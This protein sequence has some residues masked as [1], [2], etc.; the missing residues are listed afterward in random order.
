MSREKNTA[1]LK[2]T[3]SLSISVVITKILG[4]AFKVPLS[5]VLGDEGMGYFNTA[6]AIYGFFYI[7][8]TAGVPKSLA[9]VLASHS[10]TSS[11]ETDDKYILKCALRLFAKIGFVSTLLNIICAP[12]MARLVGNKNACLSILAIAPSILFVSLSGVLRGYLNSSEKLTPI[13]ISQLI[14]GSIKLALGLLLAMIGVK[15]SASVSVISAL[16]IFGITVGS[17]ISFLYMLIVAFSTKSRL[18][19]KQND[20]YSKKYIRRQIIKN[21]LPIALCSSLLNL[22]STVDLTIIIKRLVAIGMSESYANSMYGNYTT[23]AVPMFMLIIAVLSP[24]A[25]SYMPRLTNIFVKGENDRF[26]SELNKLTGITLLISVPAS[27]AFYF[28]SFDLLDILFSVQSSA[29]GA[30]MLAYLSFGVP[31]LSLLTVINT[32]LESQGR[33]TVTVLSLIIGAF[34]KISVSYVLVGSDTFGVLGA[35]IGTVV[36]YGISLIIS[37]I[38]LESSGIRTYALSKILGLYAIGFV[39]FYMPYRIIYCAVLTGNSLFAMMLSLSVSCLLFI[40][41][42]CFVHLFLIRKNVF[43]M[44]K[45]K[46]GSLYE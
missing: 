28:Y 21:A 44:H 34:T 25:T 30:E 8:C 13:A 36:S 11:D 19:K 39:S 23:L 31:L 7:L 17:G 46:Y 43:K 5:Y 45:K 33:I 22:S 40:I 12:A 27:L 3:I 38:A 26:I 35:P 20:K 37:F 14:E 16:S 10:A 9:L 15:L 18:I 2:G 41:I 32:A 24:I 4:V 6:Y 1:F 29:V 42:L